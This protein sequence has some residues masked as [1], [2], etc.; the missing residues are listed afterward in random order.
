MLVIR[1]V[2]GTRKTVLYVTLVIIMATFTGL[3]YGTFF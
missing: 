1:G 3:V 2:M